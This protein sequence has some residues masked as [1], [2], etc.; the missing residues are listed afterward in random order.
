M[1]KETEPEKQIQRT[2]ELEWAWQRFAVYDYNS[3]AMKPVF[4]R[5]QMWILMLGVFTTF[6]VVVQAQL[7]KLNILKAGSL[8]ENIIQYII[9]SLPIVTSVLVAASNRFKPGYK[10]VLLRAAAEGIKREILKYRVFM[11]LGIS[12]DTDDDHTLTPEAKLVA[13]VNE[14]N[15]HLMETEL[16]ASGLAP[17]KG[18]LPPLYAASE[19]D[20][21]FTPL[22]ADKYLEWRVVDQIN[23]YQSKTQKLSKQLEKLYWGIYIFGGLGTLLASV[24]LELWVALTTS[25]VGVFTTYMEYQQIE[26]IVIMYNQ[27]STSL[28]E[29]KSG[30]DVLPLK[31][32][33]NPEKIIFMVAKAEEILLS[34]HQ[35][36]LKNMED[37]MANLRDKDSKE[38]EKEIPQNSQ[39]SI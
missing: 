32:R 33:R 15:N 23:Y 12:L 36:W 20:D 24:G 6:L 29:L 8:I 28:Q 2:P 1:N 19:E 7:F 3:I 37:A 5:F 16:N 35:Q 21:G 18:V 25:L 38:D 39:D 4:L 17:Y 11:A 22:S 13:K 30:W 26:N 31:D 14:I 27:S 10:S 9:V 34:E